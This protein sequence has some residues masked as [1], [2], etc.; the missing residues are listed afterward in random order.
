[1]PIWRCPKC[2]IFPMYFNNLTFCCYMTLNNLA[3]T[4]GFGHILVLAPFCHDRQIALLSFNFI[5]F[6][7]MYIFPM[8]FQCFYINNVEH[9]FSSFAKFTTRHRPRDAFQCGHVP[10]VSVC[11]TYFAPLFRTQNCSFSECSKYVMFS[12]TFGPHVLQTTVCVTFWAHCRCAPPRLL[13]D[14]LA[15]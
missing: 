12:I 10:K 14:H 8:F 3:P 11:V 5:M 15:T 7:N 1:M 4:N 9:Q 2:Y 6:Q 13:G